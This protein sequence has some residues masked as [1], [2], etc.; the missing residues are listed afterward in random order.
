MQKDMVFTPLTANTCMRLILERLESHYLLL[1]T[2]VE[3]S[4]FLLK[5]LGKHMISEAS[6]SISI[7]L[8]QPAEV[9]RS[10]ILGGFTNPVSG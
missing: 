8:A 10:T 2:K 6:G 3:G 4:L 1:F 7:Q 9:N 5:R